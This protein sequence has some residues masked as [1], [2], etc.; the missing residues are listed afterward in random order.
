[1]TA[2][3]LN[4]TIETAEALQFAASPH[5]VF[6][7]RVSSGSSQ[8][9]HAVILK[10]QIHLEVGRR[11]YSAAEQERLADLFGEPSRWDQTLRSMLWT[12]TSVIVPAFIET[13]VTD[14]HAPCTFDFN[15]AATK[16]FAGVEDGEIQVAFYFNGTFFYEGDLGHVQVAHISWEKEAS[17]RMP[18]RLWRQLMD[19]YYPNTAW[20]CLE[21]DAFEQLNAYKIKHGVPTFEKALALA[22]ESANR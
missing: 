6:K 22:M 19:D 2:P 12:N 13:A 8:S 10:C 18:V 4:F 17:Y 20:L 3:D 9:I 14:L 1:M 16:Y 15:A 5:I 21:R 11:R 7:L